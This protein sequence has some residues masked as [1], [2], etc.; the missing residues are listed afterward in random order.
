MIEFCDGLQD[1]KNMSYSCY[2][3]FNFKFES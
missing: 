3:I 2:V 1:D